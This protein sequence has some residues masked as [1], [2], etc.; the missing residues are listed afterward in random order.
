MDLLTLDFRGSWR[1]V[2]CSELP[3]PHRAVGKGTGQRQKLEAQP[4][5]PALPLPLHSPERGRTSYEFVLY[6]CFLFI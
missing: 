6:S 3:A 5:P 1:P 4:C 2:S